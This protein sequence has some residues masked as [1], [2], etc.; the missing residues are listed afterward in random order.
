MKKIL[1][2]THIFIS[3]LMFSQEETAKD[4]VKNKL[5]ERFKIHNVDINNEFP[6]FGT[7]FF[8]E[9]QVIYSAQND[10]DSRM[11][12]Y[13]GSIASDGQI[14]NSRKIK[15][16]STKSYESNVTFTNDG[17]T[18]YFTRSLY[19]KVNSKKHKKNIRAS[20]A[21]LKAS[22]APNGDWT[23][24]K[25]LPFNSKNYDVGHPA[26]NSDGTKLYFT[27][28]MEGTV[29]STDIFV[30]DV[31]QDGTYSKPENLG[32][33]VNSKYKE[34]YPHFNDGV[35]YFSSYR[36]DDAY[37]KADIYAVKIYEDGS[38]SDRIH[39][40]PPINSIADDFSYI[41]NS[42]TKQGYFSSNRIRGKGADD[43]YSFNETRPLI[44]DC[45]QNID[46]EVV[47]L[48]TG[49]PVPFAE[50][51]LFDAFNQEIGR[52]STEKD[53]KFFFKNVVCSSNYEISA[54]RKHYGIKSKDFVT[55]ARHNGVTQVTI[56]LS[57]DFI[58]QKRGKKMLNIFNIH[59]DYDSSVVRADAQ[60]QLNQVVGT[61]KRY[62]RMVIELGAHTDARGG[63]AYNL[64]LSHA[65]ALST[66]RYI[67]DKGGIAQDRISGKGYGESRLLNHCD[68]KKARKCTNL[69]NETNRRSEFVITRM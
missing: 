34:A 24:V 66:I 59:F 65:R 52:M 23:N 10:E 3:V 68:N 32:E 55:L 20:I 50:V 19:G 53:G 69:E 4:T 6:S 44:F 47:D 51:I 46:G 54:E 33:K 56:P 8:K 31:L 26:L 27:S 38:I 37:G 17:K 1:F 30:V 2:L 40:S 29:G 41:F 11:D 45:Y 5:N 60:T 62:P 16:V 13:Q 48:M 12:I 15:S 57:D 64:K 39:L 7:T 49:S 9:D 43:I 21:I 36:K 22:V 58:I 28:N 14:L 42:K 35:L 63:D 67:V 18:V 61:M 25:E